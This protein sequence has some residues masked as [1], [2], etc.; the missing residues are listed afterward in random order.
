M[1]NEV[2][3]IG[4]TAPAVTDEEIF[5]YTFE[6]EG[7][8]VLAFFPGAFTKV[9][10]KE[11]CEFRDSLSKLNDL[12]A[13]VIGISVDTPFSQD[14]FREDY[15]LNFMLVSDNNKE[16]IDN[17]DVRTDFDEMGFTGLAQRALFIVKDGEIVYREVMEDPDKMPDLEKLEEELEKI[18]SE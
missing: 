13:E 5:E 18:K 15:D 10:T 6:G 4:F 9:C 17:Y 1:T 11:M 2:E 8:T 16:I 14:R 7:L 12:G 3:K